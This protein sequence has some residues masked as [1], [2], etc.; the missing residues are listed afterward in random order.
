MGGLIKQ[1]MNKKKKAGDVRPGW[2][3]GWGG[4]LFNWMNNRRGGG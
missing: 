4:G 2:G 3:G 1:D